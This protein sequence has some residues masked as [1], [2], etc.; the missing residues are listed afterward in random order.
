[1]AENKNFVIN[2]NGDGG[3]NISEEVIGIIAGLGAVEVE[4]VESL[5]G[6]LTADNI[7][8][9]G[10]GKLAKA[11]RV[12]D[13]DPGK[14]VVRMAIN[15]KYGYEIPKVSGMVQEKVKQAVETMTGLVVTAVDIR[16]A[17]VSVSS[18]N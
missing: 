7:S 9:A 11:V 17:T 10:Q 2:V 18:N 3:V 13:A 6:N 8:K 4:G 14:I 12:V 5:A 16:I 15:M 1:M